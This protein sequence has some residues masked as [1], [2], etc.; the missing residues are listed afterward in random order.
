MPPWTGSKRCSSRELARYADAIVQASLGVGKGDYLVVQG[1]PEHRELVVAIVDAGYRAGATIVDVAY[2]D[3][4]VERAHYEHGVEESLGVVTPV[5][6]APDA[7]A[8]EARSGARAVDHR[9]GRATATSTASTRSA[10]PPTTARLAEQTKFYRRANL[11]L[12]RA[13]DGRRLA[14]RLLGGAGVPGARR[15][16]KASGGSRGTSSGSAA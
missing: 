3:P 9:R 14:D 2:Y 8:R 7:R 5:G 11:D 6:D 16:S 15:R 13:L 4:L 1:Q 12:Q 10:S